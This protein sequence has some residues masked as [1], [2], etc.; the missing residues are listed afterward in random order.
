MKLSARSQVPDI[1][2]FLRCPGS[3][4]HKVGAFASGAPSNAGADA[5][6]EEGF[7]CA[8][9]ST[10]PNSGDQSRPEQQTSQAAQPTPTPE[11]QQNVASPAPGC[12]VF[13]GSSPLF[14][15][16][17]GEKNTSHLAV[18]N[19]QARILVDILV[20]GSA[21]VEANVL[22]GSATGKRRWL[23]SADFGARYSRVDGVYCTRAYD[24]QGI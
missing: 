11:P 23:N 19:N 5:M 14:D 8:T 3:H 9:S 15:H 17:S 12:F 22:S 1:S 6:V 20:V 24:A 10:R 4:P 7:V 16:P 21:R 18:G 2:S 13:T